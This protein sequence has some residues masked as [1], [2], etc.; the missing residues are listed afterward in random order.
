MPSPAAQISA[1]K[2]PDPVSLLCPGRNL[3]PES[4]SI[5]NGCFML[6][7][8]GAVYPTVIN[9]WNKRKI[10]RICSH[11][12]SLCLDLFLFLR[13]LDRQV[14]INRSIV[15]SSCALN[16]GLGLSQTRAS[17]HLYQLRS[18]TS[19]PGWVSHPWRGYRNLS[20]GSFQ[21]LGK[22]PAFELPGPP[23]P[24]PAGVQLGSA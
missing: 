9:N 11:N 14:E 10:S 6:L 12:N 23:L 17:P 3:T 2:A 21:G 24:A 1:P 15:C 4:V 16:L 19:P 7:S 13:H 8:F 22:D 18:R 5:I 20:P